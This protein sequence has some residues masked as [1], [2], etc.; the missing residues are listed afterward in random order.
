[1]SK[2]DRKGS[3][4]NM[5]WLRSTMGNQ[6]FWR[7]P[8]LVWYV[9]YKV[10]PTQPTPSQGYFIIHQ[11]YHQ[12]NLKILGHTNNSTSIV[13]NLWLLNHVIW[14][15]MQLFYNTQ[16][17][18][19]MINSSKWLTILS[20]NRIMMTDWSRNYCFALKRALKN[21]CVHV[22]NHVWLKFWKINYF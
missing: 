19:F 22:A 2:G 12:H 14:C 20:F 16:V 17:W 9:W 11:K 1:M 18:Q 6:S 13:S 5:G 4:Y 8:N 7:W 3:I 15:N 21:N 10:N